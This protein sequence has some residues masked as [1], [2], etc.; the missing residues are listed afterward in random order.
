LAW[1]RIENMARLHPAYPQ[2]V[3][4]R[5]P[6]GHSRVPTGARITVLVCCPLL[7]CGRFRVGPSC[8]IPRIAI[9]GQWSLS[10]PQPTRQAHPSPSA[11]P[12][13][14]SD[15]FNHEGEGEGVAIPKLAATLQVR[16]P[17]VWLCVCGRWVA[18][19]TCTRALVTLR[20]AGNVA[21]SPPL[22]S[23]RLLSRPRTPP[24]RSQWSR[25][26]SPS[27]QSAPRLR[28]RCRDTTRSR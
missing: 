26:A 4:G 14:A 17:R 6:P 5:H 24:P 11:S 19:T 8:T 23:R 27:C 25:G 21:G 2:I 12:T 18:D 22:P 16:M 20:R 7:L 3:Q 1:R 13:A 28:L 15:R 10:H 9:A